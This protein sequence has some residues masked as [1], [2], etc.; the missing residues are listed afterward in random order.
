MDELDFIDALSDRSSE[1]SSAAKTFLGKLKTSGIDKKQVGAAL[2]GAGILGGMAY[3]S[4]KPGRSGKSSEQNVTQRVVAS[5]EAMKDQAERDN[6]PLTFA[7]DIMTIGGSSAKR[8]ADVF[9]RHPARGAVMVA[10]FGALAGL[11]LLKSFS[12]K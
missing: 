10:P 7:E 6:R 11:M 12:P 2:A 1:R 5:N 4:M 9:A 3:A 8:L